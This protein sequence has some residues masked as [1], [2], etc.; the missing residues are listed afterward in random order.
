MSTYNSNITKVASQYHSGDFGEAPPKET[1]RPAP[2]TP[3][4]HR[5]KNSYA[6]NN[7]RT[8]YVHLQHQYH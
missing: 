6:V 3:T 8:T 2:R 4:Y 7:T 5:E 1:P